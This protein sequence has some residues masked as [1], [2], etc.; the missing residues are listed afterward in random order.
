METPEMSEMHHGS[1]HRHDHAPQDL[2]RNQ[3]LVFGALS[4]ANGP[5]SAYA[6][7]DHVRAEGMRAPLQVYRA[8]DKLVELGFVHRIET[9]NAFVACRR[10][11]CG[12][13]ASIAF[14][15][16][17]KCG[18]VAEVS[19]H[20]LG[21]ELA[22]IAARSQFSLAKSTVELRGICAPCTKVPPREVL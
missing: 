16:C 13:H 6:I 1:M 18:T 5:L 11:D 10:P 7:L 3:A 15:I 14:T 21:E 8:L 9:L 20:H 17:E 2:T 4:G 12:T 22:D 19:N